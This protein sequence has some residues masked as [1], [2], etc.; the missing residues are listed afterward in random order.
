MTTKSGLNVSR[1][2]RLVLSLSL[3]FG[4]IFNGV[5]A[6]AADRSKPTTPGNFRVTSQTAYTVTVAWS[7]SSDNSGNFNYHLSGAYGVTPVVLPKTATSYTFT[8]LYPG[9]DYWFFIYAKDAAGNVSGQGNANTR[10]LRD[11]TPPSTA[12]VVSVVETGATYAHL[13]WTPAQDDGPYLFYEVWVNG[14]LY[15]TTGKNI[16]TNTLRFLEPTTTYTVSVR[17]Y[18]YGNNRSPFSAPVNVT[19]PSPNPNDIMP[20]TVPLNLRADTFG[21][22]STETHL[23]WTPSTDDF[24]APANIRYDVYVNGV[25]QDILFGSGGPSIVYADFGES[26]IE[27]TATDTAGNTSAAATVIVFF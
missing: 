6:E 24:E 8:G 26:L 25:L 27:V 10:T 1:Y 14:S 5:S 9:N 19:T 13:S 23:R 3:L 22:G 16:T 18:D 4:M 21:D 15:V 7:P 17:A 2:V 12:P 11:I 20:P